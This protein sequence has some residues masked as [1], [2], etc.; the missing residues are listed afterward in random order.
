RIVG[1][2]GESRYTLEI[3]SGSTSY[4][5]IKLPQRNQAGQQATI[6]ASR[7]QHKTAKR[8]Q[9]EIEAAT[10][11][12]KKGN[13]RQAIEH[14]LLGETFDPDNFDIVSNLGALYLKERDPE[15]ALPWLNRAWHIDPNDAPNNTNLSAYY[16]YRDDYAKA[17]EFAVASLKTNPNSTHA[18]YMLA[19]SLLKQ[20][21]DTENARSHLNQ[22]Q[23]AFAPAKNLLLSMQPKE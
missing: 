18:R 3:Q 4:L 10:R 14:L 21:K 6:S 11:E 9:K 17:E 5:E 8:A 1:Q 2:A 20:G 12:F 15:K 13:R 23:G 19:L 22:I 7:L 16:A